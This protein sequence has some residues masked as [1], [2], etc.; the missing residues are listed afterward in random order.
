M[1]RSAKG[2]RIKEEINSLANAA[3]LSE[4]VSGL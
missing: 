2:Q 3:G 4:L 1:E